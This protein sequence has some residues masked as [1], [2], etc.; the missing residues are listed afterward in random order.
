VCSLYKKPWSTFIPP[1]CFAHFEFHLHKSQ[2]E[3]VDASKAE[4]SL[5]SRVVIRHS[6][7]FQRGETRNLRDV[8]ENCEMCR[9]GGY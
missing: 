1:A 8:L 2:V 3:M 4:G 5:K 7:L 6:S 9:E